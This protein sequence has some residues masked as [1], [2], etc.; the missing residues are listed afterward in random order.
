[1]WG[2]PNVNDLTSTSKLAN[3]EIAFNEVLPK[4]KAK[5]DLQRLRVS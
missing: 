1:V 4:Q 2:D 3:R 5:N